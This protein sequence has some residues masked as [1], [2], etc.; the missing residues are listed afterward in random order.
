MGW[1]RAHALLIA[2]LARFRLRHGTGMVIGR[3]DL[4]TSRVM[5]CVGREESVPRGWWSL[6][7]SVGNTSIQLKL[8]SHGTLVLSVSR[9][10]APIRRGFRGSGGSFTDHQMIAPIDAHG[11]GC[12]E[13]NRCMSRVG[14][15]PTVRYRLFA[16]LLLLETDLNGGG[17][18]SGGVKYTLVGGRDRLDSSLV[19]GGDRPA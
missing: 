8:V 6:P 13:P 12:Q 19:L 4:L 9:R 18:G 2:L 16:Y 17:H 7:E 14:W 11:Q 10:E 3:P 5:A 1:E 15:R